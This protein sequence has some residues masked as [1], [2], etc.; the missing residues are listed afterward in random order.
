[1]WLTCRIPGSRHGTICLLPPGSDELPECSPGYKDFPRDLRSRG[2]MC[3]TLSS[4]RMRRYISF[5]SSPGRDMN[6]VLLL[7]PSLVPVSCIV[8]R[9]LNNDVSYISLTHAT[10][11]TYLF[12]RS[13]VRT[14]SVG[15]SF[16]VGSDEFTAFLFLEGAILVVVCGKN[17]REAE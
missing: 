1:M 17:Q 9:R 11:N 14:R 8:F 10:S 16:A 13:L 4:T 3:M 12:V 7:S 2:R 5:L 6:V 15:E